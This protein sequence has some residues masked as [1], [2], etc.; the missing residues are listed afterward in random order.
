MCTMQSIEKGL[1]MLLTYGNIKKSKFLKYIY[2]SDYNDDEY[3]KALHEY[4]KSIIK[5]FEKSDFIKIYKYLHDAK[6]YLKQTNGN[7]V[8]KVKTYDSEEKK[9]VYFDIIF[10]K[11]KILSWN[12]VKESGHISRLNKKYK[13][14]EYGYEEFYEDNGKKYV[15]LIL[16]GNKVRKGLYYPMITLNYENIRINRYK[17]EIHCFD[18][19]T[20]NLICTE[21][22]EIDFSKLEFIFSDVIK[23]DPDLIYEYKITKENMNKFKTG[24]T[25]EFDKFNYFLSY[26]SII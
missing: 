23:D 12:T 1:K 3:R 20:G 24:T 2:L 11:A 15:T 4:N 18:K 13:P 26:I 25:F 17:R 21:D 5:N 10:E 16:F 7:V 14:R 9:L 22:I 8:I 19:T 6:I